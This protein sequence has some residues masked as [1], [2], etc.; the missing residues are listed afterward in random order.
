[1]AIHY[2]IVYQNSSAQPA[3]GNSNAAT[4]HLV[5][6]SVVKHP[7]GSTSSNYV[8]TVYVYY[9]NTTSTDD[10]V[11][12]MLNDAF[13]PGAVRAVVTQG[14]SGEAASLQGDPD[15][16][17]GGWQVTFNAPTGSPSSVTFYFGVGTPPTKV[18]VIIK[19]QEESFSC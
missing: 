19:K 6:H 12:T 16:I 18:K 14:S 1:M 8:D 5:Q 10:F 3:C 11:L 4:V 15:Q 7:D 17:S 2:E 9:A 13:V